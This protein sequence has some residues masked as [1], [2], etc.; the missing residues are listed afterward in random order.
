M[1]TTAVHP[2]YSI[3][4]H[5]LVHDR[6]TGRIFKHRPC[7]LTNFDV[8]RKHNQIIL[9]YNCPH[10]DCGDRCITESP[11]SD[12]RCLQCH[13]S[14]K[15]CL[16]MHRKHYM[17]FETQDCSPEIARRMLQS[18]QDDIDKI[19]DWDRRKQERQIENS[20]IRLLYKPI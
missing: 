12:D 13:F 1:L 14:D 19:I 3:L 15:P 9:W 16:E 4:E 17:V 5:C 6:D 18:L 20:K 2:S 8:V 11:L 10:R 7:E